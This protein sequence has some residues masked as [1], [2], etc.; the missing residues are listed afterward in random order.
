LSFSSDQPD[1]DNVWSKNVADLKTKY[2]LVFCLDLLFISIS[3]NTKGM[4][5]LKMM[6]F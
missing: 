3:K 5:F 6:K 1:D 2:I 4:N